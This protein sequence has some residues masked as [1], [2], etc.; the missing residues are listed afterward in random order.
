MTI[1]TVSPGSISSRSGFSVIEILISV[2]ILTV[3]LLA[4]ASGLA[5]SSRWHTLVSNRTEMVHMADDR[6]ELLRQAGVSRTADTVKLVPGGS[7]TTSV[8][9][10][11]DT[12]TS[13]GGQVFI[14]RWRVI[15]GPGTTRQ[16]TLRLTPLVDTKRMPMQMDFTTLMLVL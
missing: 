3:G 9:N 4:L 5:T 1:R 12:T 7:L 6:L 8:A 2:V 11:S 10:H 13:P 14:R 16:V 15:A